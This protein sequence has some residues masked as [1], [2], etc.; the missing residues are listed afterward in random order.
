VKKPRKVQLACISRSYQ[1]FVKITP[2]F[3]AIESEQSAPERKKLTHLDKK[4]AR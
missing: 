3:L 4:M 1:G 2:W